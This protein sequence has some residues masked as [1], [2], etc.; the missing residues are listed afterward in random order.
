[1]KKGTK[2]ELNTLSIDEDLHSRLRAETECIESHNICLEIHGEPAGQG[3]KSIISRGGKTWLIEGSSD[4]ARAKHKSWRQGAEQAARDWL[5]AN[6][7]APLAEPVAIHIQFRFAPTKSDPY[8]RLHR[9]KPDGDHL[10]RSTHDALVAAGLLADDALICGGQWSKVYAWPGETVGATITITLLGE[11][12]ADNRVR[13]KGLYAA[14]RGERPRIRAVGA[15]C[16]DT[17]QCNNN[18]SR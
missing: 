11:V 4:S 1:M 17:P 18:L 14:K 9:V 12:E 16:H 5:R 15:V 3:S 13:L 2:E 6:P 10:L 8:R 7:R